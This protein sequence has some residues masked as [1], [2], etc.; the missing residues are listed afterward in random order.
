M[1]YNIIELMVIACGSLFIVSAL[2]NKEYAASFDELHKKVWLRLAILSIVLSAL[3]SIAFVLKLPLTMKEQFVYIWFFLNIMIDAYIIVFLIVAA[4]EGAKRLTDRISILLVKVLLFIIPSLFI[5][6]MIFQHYT[7]HEWVQ[8]INTNFIHMID[9]YKLKLCNE[10]YITQGILY[11]SF[12]FLILLIAS[13][14]LGKFG[15][16]LV[17]WTYG[18]FAID[19]FVKSILFFSFYF[20]PFKI[21]SSFVTAIF[22]IVFSMALIRGK[23]N[24]KFN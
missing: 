7:L 10:F 17:R 24:A 19:S 5:F 14:V 23:F 22:L 18:L 4:T 13:I 21:F 15:S 9:L 16:K 20:I 11:L 12:T 3:A 8:Y 1:I 2:T 6:L